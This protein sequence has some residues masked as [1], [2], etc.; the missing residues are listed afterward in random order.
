MRARLMIVLMLMLAIPILGVG[1]LGISTYRN[2]QTLAKHRR[3]ALLLDKLH[4]ID[5]TLAKLVTT[6]EQR[7]QDLLRKMKATPNAIR[8]QT[9]QERLSRQLFR[10]NDQGALV[11]PAGDDLSDEER[12]FL[13]RTRRIFQG[14]NIF[15][16]PSETATGRPDCNWLVW[17][18]DEG[19]QLIYWC[20]VDKGINGVE[21]DP[22]VLAAD[23]IAA[24][25]EGTPSPR[26]RTAPF[27]IRLL[28][29]NDEILYQ[30]GDYKPS[31]ND[32]A[33]TS[34][35]LSPPLTS[36]RLIYHAA[37]VPDGAFGRS[38]AL[39]LTLG[40][41]A[42]LLAV[43]L[44]GVYFVRESSRD[45]RAAR[46]RMTFVNQVSHELKTPLT[47]LRMYAELLGEYLEEDDEKGQRY[48][49]VIV[50]ES[51]RLSR[52]IANV[53]SFARHA[54][55][56]LTIRKSDTVPDQIIQDTVE[57]F[58]PVFE[59][60]G[61]DIRLDLD[62]ATPRAMDGDALAQIVANLLSNVEK[63]AVKG[64]W[65]SIES[66]LNNDQL[67]AVVEDAGEGIPVGKEEEIFKP[68]YRLSNRLTDR[69]AGTGIGLSISR[70]L[71]R[72]HGGDLRVVPTQ[73]GAAFQIEITAP[74]SSSPK[75]DTA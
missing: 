10:L 17:H 19:V 8:N 74:Q 12:A 34:L 40:F 44:L 20:A 59:Q 38:A 58:R 39:G 2:E 50:Q 4:D 31:E 26:K 9:Q 36:F 64:K 6:Y 49:N 11:F 14:G 35:K 66:R 67:T 23:L 33:V 41:S 71:A 18:F 27:R 5:D 16:K 60:A 54:R 75:G 48:V 22:V 24:L 32:V 13:T 53:L 73:K 43:V 56:K 61:I 52:L 65:V 62:A 42:L 21:L 63:Y 47:N 30:W 15:R 29:V 37:P 25:P 1:W 45:A 28:D 70:E 3:D 72:R 68:F 46:D 57:R 51:E 7:L 69:A 55:G